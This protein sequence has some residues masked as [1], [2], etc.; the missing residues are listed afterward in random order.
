[1]SWCALRDGA[2]AKQVDFSHGSV[3]CRELKRGNLLILRSTKQTI[4][5]ILHRVVMSVSDRKARSRAIPVFCIFWARSC[6][7]QLPTRPYSQAVPLCLTCFG[8]TFCR[9]GGTFLFTACGNKR[10]EVCAGLVGT[11][12]T[13]E[14]FTSCGY[15][16]VNATMFR[17]GFEMPA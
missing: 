9:S 15:Y 4:V 12:N 1:M 11:E 17:V 16:L 6:P 3:P 10:G 14:L 13:F 8:K 5:L 7:S 2:G